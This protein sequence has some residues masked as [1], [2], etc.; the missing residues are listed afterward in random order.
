MLPQLYVRRAGLFLQAVEHRSY[1]RCHGDLIVA[2]DLADRV[3]IAGPGCRIQ[4][5]VLFGRIIGILGRPPDD[6]RVIGI[7][8]FQNRRR[9][10]QSGI[11]RAAGR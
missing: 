3:R 6:D 11:N 7:A 8:N 4:V 10:N 2:A 1:W 5:G 9:Q